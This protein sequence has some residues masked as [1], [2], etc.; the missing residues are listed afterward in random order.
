MLNDFFFSDN[1]K[2]RKDTA[3]VPPFGFSATPKGQSQEDT[4]V[5]KPSPVPAKKKPTAPPSKCQKRGT[6]VTTSLE[7]Y[8]PSASSDNVSIAACA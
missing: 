6:V 4:V 1:D 8:Q 3:T 2:P 7:V 5:A